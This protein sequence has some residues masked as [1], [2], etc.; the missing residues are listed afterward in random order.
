MDIVFFTE[1]RRVGTKLLRF[2]GGLG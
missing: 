2:L 1:I